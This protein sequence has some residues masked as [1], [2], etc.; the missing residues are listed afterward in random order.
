MIKGPVVE[1]AR[2]LKAVVVDNNLDEVGDLLIQLL[3]KVCTTISVDCTVHTQ[4]MLTFAAFI[5]GVQHGVSLALETADH[6]LA[7]VPLSAFVQSTGPRI[8]SHPSD[9]R[10][11][12]RPVGK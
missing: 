10:L 12:I 11:V 7:P 4:D 6:A 5:V 1:V 2:S 9:W 8:L 3:D